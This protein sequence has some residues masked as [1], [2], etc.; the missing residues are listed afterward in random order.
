VMPLVMIDNLTSFRHADTVLNLVKESRPS[1]P[2]TSHC[3]SSAPAG[4]RGH[5]GHGQLTY[6]LVPGIDAVAR[7]GDGHLVYTG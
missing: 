7:T 1:R 3:T 4:H 5:Y 2:V 6:P